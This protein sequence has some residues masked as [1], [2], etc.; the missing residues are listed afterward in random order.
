MSIG[1]LNTHPISL[2]SIPSFRV[3]SSK[4]RPQ[5][6]RF[7]VFFKTVNFLKINVT[8]PSPR[9]G[10]VD[11][12]GVEYPLRKPSHTVRYRIEIDRMTEVEIDEQLREL[13]WSYRQFILYDREVTAEEQKHLERQAK[14][15][16]DTL[17]AAFGDEELYHQS[18][19]I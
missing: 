1:K 11:D 19:S 4:E 6:V 5:R 18:D 7:S 13:V 17:R 12:S 14:V 2:I 10:I 9:T 3:P 15:A 16:W 8:H